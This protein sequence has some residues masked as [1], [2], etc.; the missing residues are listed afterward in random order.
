MQARLPCETI[1]NDKTM[2]LP[3]T[4]AVTSVGCHLSLTLLVLGFLLQCAMR[5]GFHNWLHWSS[6]VESLFSY[7]RSS[8]CRSLT[9][10]GLKS[11]AWYPLPSSSILL[12]KHCPIKEKR[13]MIHHC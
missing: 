12:H 1:M 6:L 13:G 9:V 2:E 7:D 8:A 10:N 5:M 4:V 11:K 3:S